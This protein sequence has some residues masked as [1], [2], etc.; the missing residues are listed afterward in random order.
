M[1]AGLLILPQLCAV[2]HGNGRLLESNFHLVSHI[3]RDSSIIH[4]EDFPVGA[5][6]SNHF[7]SLFQVFP[8]PFLLLALSHLGT[9]EEE[10]E[11]D[12]DKDQRK[13]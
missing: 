7:I 11:N 2:V 9:N 13:K 1:I 5:A 12:D 3:Q 8:E 6:D 4:F 10:V